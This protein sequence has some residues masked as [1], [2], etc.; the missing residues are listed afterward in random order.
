MKTYDDLAKEIISKL[1]KITIGMKF[2]VLN[3]IYPEH[4][5]PTN[6]KNISEGFTKPLALSAKDKIKIR[7]KKNSVFEDFV[8]YKKTKK[9]K[10]DIL[11]VINTINNY[12]LCENISRP[13]EISDKYYN[14]E[15][16]KYIKINYRDILEGNI[17]QIM[18]VRK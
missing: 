2:E 15:E 8:N 9:E 4:T 6:I 17:K 10:G 11:V 18:R 12:F 5:I 13:K 1:P 7:K 16:I 3:S 14:N